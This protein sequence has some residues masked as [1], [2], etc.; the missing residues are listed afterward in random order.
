MK[1]LLFAFLLT[2]AVM[3]AQA[4]GGSTDKVQKSETTRPRTTNTKTKTHSKLASGKKA[5]HEKSKKGSGQTITPP[6]K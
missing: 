4:T 3:L 5:T 2:A 6:P 1:K